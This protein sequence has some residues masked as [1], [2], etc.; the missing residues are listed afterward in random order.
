MIKINEYLDLLK[1][2]YKDK[3]YANK[4]STIDII[5]YINEK[6]NLN[7]MEN[8]SNKYQH[9]IEIAKLNCM[10]VESYKN[11][12][13]YENMSIKTF[14]IVKD[15]LSA[16][17]YSTYDYNGSIS[18]ILPI[19]LMIELNT[20]Y[21]YSN[22]NDLMQHLILYQGISQDDIDNNTSNLTLYLRLLDEIT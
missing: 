1:N 15:S 21:L 2:K 17:Y 14:E 10:N 8:D 11:K 20:G 16:D 13:N 19:F 22:S 18:S 7:E 6:F 9:Q 12:V 3:I 5:N 4:K